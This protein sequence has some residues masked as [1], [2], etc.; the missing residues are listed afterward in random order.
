[1]LVKELCKKIYI[2]ENKFELQNIIVILDLC[3]DLFVT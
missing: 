1:M 3:I 2:E